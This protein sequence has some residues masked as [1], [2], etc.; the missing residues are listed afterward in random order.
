MTY[1]VY[2]RWPD[3]KVSDKTVTEDRALAELA[4]KTLVA[5]KDLIGKP[6]GAAFTARVGGKPQQIAYHAFDAEP[7]A[8]TS[9]ATITLKKS[10]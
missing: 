6:V 3:Q 5:R 2:L 10:R 7:P 1:R 4:F 9:G 8:P